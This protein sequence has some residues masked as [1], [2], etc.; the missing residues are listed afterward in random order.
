MKPQVYTL[1]LLFMIYYFI[2]ILMFLF[3]KF[4]S[5]DLYCLKDVFSKTAK[6]STKQN[7]K[8]VDCVG[9]AEVCIV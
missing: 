6:L 3:W 1:F 8:N 5:Y 2:H 7:V 4:F 9:I